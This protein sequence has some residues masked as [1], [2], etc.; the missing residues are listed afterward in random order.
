ME[1]IYNQND[2]Q[3][4]S[5]QSE[6]EGEKRWK[7]ARKG[8]LGCETEIEEGLWASGKLWLPSASG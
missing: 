7:T 5:R 8:E 3:L 2:N 1:L 6:A 4:Q